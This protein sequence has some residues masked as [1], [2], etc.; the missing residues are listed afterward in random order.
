[1]SEIQYKTSFGYFQNEGREF[2][3][4]ELNTPRQ[5]VNYFWNMR[6]ISGVSHHGGGDGLYK[7][8]TM[9][10]ID[11]R[12][13][14]LMIRDGH[15]YFYIRDEKTGKFWSPGWHP[16]HHPVDS[17]QC[18]HGF[19]YSIIDS[20]ANGIQSRLR[21]FVPEN[22]PCEIWTITLKNT[23]NEEAALKFY[24]FAD[25][26]LMGYP[27]Y[28]DY[29]GMLFGEYYEDIYAAQGC[30]RAAERTHEVFDGFV[31]SDIKPSGYETSQQA[32]L[33]IYG[34][35]NKPEA[36]VRGKLMNSLASSENLAS[37]LE[38]THKLAPNER[39]TFNII[40]GASSGYEMT[41]NI[42]SQL[43]QKDVI[44]S[45]FENL[46]HRKEKMVNR[47][48]INTPDQRVNFIIN[49]WIK[50]QIQVY[51]DVGSD[52]GRGFR[53]SM[54]LLWA[55]ASYD[56]T[57][58]KNMLIECLSHQYADG[59][60]LRGWLPIDDHHYSDGPVWITPVVDAYLKETGEYDILEYKVPFYDGGED[61]IWQHVLRGLRH[62]SDDTGKNGLTRCHFGDWNDSL[63]GVG[64]EGRGES[65]WTTIGIIYGL[66]IAARIARIIRK[67]E[68]ET[69]ELMNRAQLLKNML[70]KNAWDGNWYLR[71]INDYGEKIGTHAEK[72][73]KIFLLP[74]V[75]AI[76]AESVDED[77]KRLLYKIIDTYLDTPYGS[78]TLYPVYTKHNPRIG[79]VTLMQPGMWENGSPYCHA[80][81]FKIIADC[82]G[83]R[84][85][86]AYRSFK[87]AMP[88]SQWNPSTHSGCEPYVLTNN[89]LGPENRRAGKSL[90]A[91]MTGSAGWYYRAMT[92]WLIGVRAD[93]N[94]LLIDPC[95]PSEWTLCELERSFRGARYGITIHNPDKLEKGK[96]VI[97]VDGKKIRGNIIPLHENGQTH[98]VV[99]TLYK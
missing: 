2:V 90:W 4:T 80:N 63:T 21:V 42:V 71:A 13:R 34:F 24:S 29:F 6:F 9:Q 65:V 97:K 83:G 68:K 1:M 84:G 89:Y 91:W 85:N 96:T 41:Y 20:Q 72:E 32:F 67:D 3:V 95:L 99:V 22:D 81:G 78:R 40:I 14:S 54:Q 57:Y 47:V 56:K 39:H 52:N 94:G 46:K 17:Y 75:W 50:Q 77:R 43:F 11:K 87:K 18:T 8:R 51:A 38:H 92:E 33:G 26:Y 53:D 45:E 31:A 74:Q 27:R 73:G 64:I 35:V 12:G 16:V 10:Y 37:V 66:K 30:N 49:G 82:Y 98:K 7:N 61:T 79:R 93:Y 69:S 62:G 88:D 19:G 25:W 86:Q 36:V 5:L 15:R 76:M 48:K 28:C 23:R 59:H 60:T 55:T 44:E 70:D 58:T